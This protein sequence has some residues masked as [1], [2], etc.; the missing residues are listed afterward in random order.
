MPH[1]FIQILE[2]PEERKRAF[3]RTALLIAESG[4]VRSISRSSELS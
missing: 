1:G 3:E 4:G 2:T